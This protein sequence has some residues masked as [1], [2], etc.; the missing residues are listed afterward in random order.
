MLTQTWAQINPAITSQQ[1]T[2]VACFLLAGDGQQMLVHNH[3]A[4]RLIT[5]NQQEP[6]DLDR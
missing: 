1:E 5:F 3:Q 6:L 2:R 4:A